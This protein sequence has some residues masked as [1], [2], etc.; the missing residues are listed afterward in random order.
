MAFQNKRPR[1][2][3]LYRHTPNLKNQKKGDKMQTYQ[4][5]VEYQ[6]KDATVKYTSKPYNTQ[7]EALTDLNQELKRAL[8]KEQTVTAAYVT[9]EEMPQEVVGILMGGVMELADQEAQERFE[10][11]VK[12]LTKTLK[13]IRGE[14]SF[15]KGAN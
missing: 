14:E 2:T 10:K 11:K 12:E 13:A 5:V 15:Y 8:K 6:R 3:I 9:A 1:K 7:K 4:A